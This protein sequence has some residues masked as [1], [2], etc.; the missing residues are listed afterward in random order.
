MDKSR[1]ITKTFDWSQHIVSNLQPS[2]SSSSSSSSSISATVGKNLNNS[3]VIDSNTSNNGNNHA[4][5]LISSSPPMPS[6]TINGVKKQ[7]SFKIDHQS[8][9]HKSDDD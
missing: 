4:F 2:P 5:S 9:K 6:P 1:L 8:S 7:V 3:T